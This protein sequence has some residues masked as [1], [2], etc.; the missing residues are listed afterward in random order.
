M[1]QA[2]NAILAI[3]S[4]DRYITNVPGKV[5]QPFSDRI[6][7][8]YF[9]GSP[10][11]N[12]F[13]IS[14]PNA[15]MNGYIEKILISQ[16]QLQYNLPTI[17]PNVNDKIVIAVETGAGTGLYNITAITIP[18]GF[19]TPNDLAVQLQVALQAI[20]S[21]FEVNYVSINQF[22]F[23]NNSN[24]RFYFL[25]PVEL[26]IAGGQSPENIIK[27]LK[28]YKLLGIN[29]NN[30]NPEL[31]QYSTTPPQFLYTPYIDI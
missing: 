25:P 18:Y 27:I 16:I 22:E 7:K 21:G 31:F 6:F 26:A 17:I 5:N 9:G 3:S 13:S 4:T 8:E 19:Y 2:P 29:I 24:R 12:D 20:N 10:F 15:L 14:A 28:T 30:A 11:S 23:V 1:A